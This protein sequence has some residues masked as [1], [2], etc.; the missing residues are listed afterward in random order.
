MEHDVGV[1]HRQRCPEHRLG[2][3]GESALQGVATDSAA[4][5]PFVR[6]AVSTWQ[7]G[8]SIQ[9]A[10]TRQCPPSA[11][12]PYPFFAWSVNEL[13]VNDQTQD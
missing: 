12:V 4:S 5:E 3:A 11:S 13:V 1:P 8:T 10:D 2:D 9:V 7:T 6:P